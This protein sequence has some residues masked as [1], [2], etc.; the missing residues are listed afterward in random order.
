MQEPD[1][2][3]AKPGSSVLEELMDPAALVSTTSELLDAYRTVVKELQDASRLAPSIVVQRITEV[4]SGE[5]RDVSGVE[6][7]SLVESVLLVIGHR[8]GSTHSYFSAT[9]DVYRWYGMYAVNKT[10]EVLAN[11]VIIFAF[12]LR[13]L[14][15]KRALALV[16]RCTR[17]V[18]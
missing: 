13:M 12:K 1:F 11:G 17:A 5:G 10:V 15:F 18:K 7:G 6:A 3:A 14:D 2:A 4:S 16:A 9:P 8:A